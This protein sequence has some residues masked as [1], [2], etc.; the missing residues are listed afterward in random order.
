[1]NIGERIAQLRKSRSMSQFQLAKTL[2][3]ATSTLGMYETNKRKPNMEM[4]EKLADFFGVSV[5]FLLGR[6]EKDDLKTADL[7]DDDTIF[8]FEGKPIP[9]QDLEYMKRLLRGGRK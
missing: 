2:N 1:M 8:T 6:P 5:D 7:A 9:E 4:L 3:I